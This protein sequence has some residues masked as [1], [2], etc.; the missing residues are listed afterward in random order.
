VRPGAWLARSRPLPRRS[1][2]GAGSV[3]TDGVDLVWMEGS[4]RVLGE[5][6]YPTRDIVTAPFTTD[7]AAL[8][9]RRLRSQIAP[10]F[11]DWSQAYEVACGRAARK[12]A[13]SGRGVQI[14]RLSDGRGWELPETPFVWRPSTIVGMTCDEIFLVVQT[15]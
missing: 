13:S 12:G 7:P 1:V 9:P 14:V 5:H 4:G 10:Q 3:G 15:W 11:G 6:H 8:Q 2:R